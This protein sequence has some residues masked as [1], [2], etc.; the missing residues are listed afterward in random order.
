AVFVP[1][2][3]QAIPQYPERMQ[4]KPGVT[5]LAQFKLPADTDLDSVRAKLAYDLHYI[6]RM[7]FWLDFRIILCT[8]LKMLGI[9]FRIL[10]ALFRLPTLA[11]VASHNA[12][13]MPTPVTPPVRSYRHTGV[14]EPAC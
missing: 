13:E 14:A 2:L 10:T 8:G 4:V 7:G 12:Q 1:G 3:A 11:P 5:G 9:P 6:E